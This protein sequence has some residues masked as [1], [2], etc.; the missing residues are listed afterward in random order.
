MTNRVVITGAGI[1]SPFGIGM[2]EFW[3]AIAVQKSGLSE[4]SRLSDTALPGN[5][6]GELKELSDKSARNYLT[7]TQ[8][9]S[10]KVMCR[11]ILLGVISANLCI[12]QS[13][14]DV[15]TPDAID[16]ERLGIAF[17]ANQMFSPPEVLGEGVYAKDDADN[18]AVCSDDGR[19]LFDQWGEYGLRRMDPLWLLKYL[20]NMPACHIGIRAEA[21]GPNNS[22]TLAEASGNSAL[23]EAFRIIARGRADMMLCGST[24]S[25]IHPVKCLH[26][27]LSEELA[28]Y[29][30][31]PATWCRPFDA[32][33][34]G[35]V[36]GEGACTFLFE[37]ESH[38]TARGADVL[39]TVLGAGSS[40]VLG[41]DGVPNH[42]MAL[43]NAM[44]S[45]MRDADISPADIGHIN[46]HGLGEQQSDLAEANAIQDVFGDRAA[47]VPVTAPKSFLGN[48]GAACGTLE[49]AASLCGLKQGVVP[50]TI[51]CEN[52][53]EA[54]GL[55]IVRGD[56]LP[57]Q[58]KTVLNVNVT[59]SGQAAAL[60]IC[61][62]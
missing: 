38:A 24:G 55:N 44:K 27:A 15:E 14:L 53:D 40:C 10:K 57:V 28:E 31:D 51:S 9:K 5:V 1:L 46:A 8:K 56:V 41:I 29:D 19:F 47:T 61:G 49:L 21:R 32:T 43:S 60:V 50:A 45:A 34:R 36:V 54:C 3:S 13:G 4:I 18:L 12:D 7:R 17:G 48:S 26:A 22:L 35:Q 20:P 6:A 39:G 11:E 59:A 33:R 37:K 25:R 42:R 16:H 2:D 30:D 23:G 58:N 62:A 52:P